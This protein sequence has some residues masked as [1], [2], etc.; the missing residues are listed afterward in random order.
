MR[1]QPD[2]EGIVSM[3]LENNRI[4][5]FA[6]GLEGSMI[7]DGF[8]DMTENQLEMT[9]RL[10]KSFRRSSVTLTWD[11]SEK[12]LFALPDRLLQRFIGIGAKILDVE[13]LK[14]EGILNVAL[15]GFINGN[16]S[17]K[18]E[19]GKVEIHNFRNGKSEAE[20]IAGTVHELISSGR[21]S[22]G[23]I[24][25]VSRDMPAWDSPIVNYLIR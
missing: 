10:V 23:D 5:K 15:S 16:Y 11:K 2:H 17:L 9:S 1:T 19:S 22:S 7:F 14:N 25:I 8:Y 13:P 12:D 24:M 20:W 21:Y 18:A 3:A 4:E 6:E